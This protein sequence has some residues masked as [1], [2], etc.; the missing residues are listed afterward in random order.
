MSL[1]LLA[2]CYIGDPELVPEKRIEVGGFHMS[3]RRAGIGNPIVV[4]FPG[5]GHWSLHWS[6]VQGEVAKFAKVISYDP[7]GLGDSEF[8]S[9]ARSLVQQAYELHRLLEL[10]GEKGPYLLVGHSLGGMVA[11]RFANLY[12]QESISIFSCLLSDLI[13]QSIYK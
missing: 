3:L 7:P 11:Y 5:S 4:L 1:L 9:P 8:G 12:K 10:S 13:K 6:L 2:L